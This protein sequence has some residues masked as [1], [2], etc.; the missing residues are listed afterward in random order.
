RLFH[1]QERRHGV[2]VAAVWV[3][4]PGDPTLD[5][6]DVHLDGD[7]ELIRRDT[8][9]QQC[10]TQALVGHH[11]PVSSDRRGDV[12]NLGE[13][14]CTSPAMFAILRRTSVSW[15]IV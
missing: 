12:S 8:A 11:H 7:G 1:P 6:L 3:P 2:A 13:T 9:F 14:S 4:T 5:R 15:S 10:S